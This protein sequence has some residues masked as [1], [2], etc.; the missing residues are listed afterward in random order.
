MERLLNFWFF[1][2]HFIKIPHLVQA[3]ELPKVKKS[4]I[5]VARKIDLIAPNW[6]CS[7]SSFI[8]LYQTHIVRPILFLGCWTVSLNAWHLITFR[9]QIRIILTEF[10]LGKHGTQISIVNFV[11]L[12]SHHTLQNSI[13][14]NSLFFS[15]FEPSKLHPKKIRI[16]NSN[17]QKAFNKKVWKL[18]MKTNINS[19]DNERRR[20]RPKVPWLKNH[21]VKIF[22]FQKGKFS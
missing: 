9:R 4:K 11:Q 22:V 2:I 19:E 18:E 6:V 3:K 13:S 16:K 7:F 17:Q 1:E 10:L 12:L 21:L 8:R 15:L 20:R 5:R 14:I